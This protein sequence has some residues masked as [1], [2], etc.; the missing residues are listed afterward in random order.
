MNYTLSDKCIDCLDTI[1]E[2]EY[3]FEGEGKKRKSRDKE[4]TG[5]PGENKASSSNKW[6]ETVSSIFGMVSSYV[7]SKGKEKEK[8]AQREI[9]K[10]KTKQKELELKQKELEL[11]QKELEQYRLNIDNEKTSKSKSTDKVLNVKAGITI[12]SLLLLAGAA[13]L[14]GRNIIQKYKN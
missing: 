1:H 6:D 2:A 4:K 9:E 7:T 11:K 12:A 14:I 13:L 8:K 3:K 10:E 5:S